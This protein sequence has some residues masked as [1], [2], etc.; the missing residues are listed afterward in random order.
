MS[1]VSP[2]GA[3]GPLFDDDVT[4]ATGA[5]LTTAGVRAVGT[6][7]AGTDVGA[8]PGADEPERAPGAADG[9][10]VGGDAP[11]RPA[12]DADLTVIDNSLVREGLEDVFVVVQREGHR[13]GHDIIRCRTTEE[14]P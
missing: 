5:D 7:V 6:S 1:P 14:E 13:W 2:T 4:S 9:A 12:A 11:A 8:G 3:A 10:G